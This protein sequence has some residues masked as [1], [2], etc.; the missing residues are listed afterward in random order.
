[1]IVVNNALST[2]DEFTVALLHMNGTDAATAFTDETGKT[3]TAQGNAQI[4]TGQ[5]KFGGASGLFDGTGDYIDT[6][7][8]TDWQLDGGA[9][10]NLWTIDFWVRFNG[11]PDA[12]SRSNGSFIRLIYS[13]LQSTARNTIS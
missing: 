1:M 13:R 4:D 8:S 9:D 10:A 5:S 7:D 12:T 3:W 2:V 11:D 6:P